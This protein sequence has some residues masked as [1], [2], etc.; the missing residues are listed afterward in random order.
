MNSLRE[1]VNPVFHTAEACLLVNAQ[2]GDK[3]A[4]NLLGLL[5]FGK[6]VQDT[7]ENDMTPEMREFVVHRLNPGF[8]TMVEA[9][10]T[11]TTRLILESGLSRVVDLPCGFTPRGLKMAGTAIDYYGLDLPAVTEKMAPVVES[12]IGESTKIAYRAVDATNL[13]SL[14][15]ALGASKEPVLIS[16]EGMLMYF[17]QSE[18]DEV[19]RNIRAILLE[20]GGEW[21]TVDNQMLSAQNRLMEVLLAGDPDEIEKFNTFSRE[22]LS[23][24]APPENAFLKDNAEQYVGNMGF[25]LRKVPVYD[26][27]PPTLHALDHLPGKEKDKARDVFKDMYFWIMTAEPDGEKILSREEEQFGISARQEG[28]ELLIALTGRLDTITSP[29]LL[30]EFRK[31]QEKNPVNQISIDMTH[32]SYISSAGLRVLLI[33]YKALDD[34]EC[35]KLTGVSKEVTEILKTT[36]FDQFFL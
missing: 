19:F 6:A 35:F 3:D 20:H 22:R 4:K 2:M 8:N 28:K 13:D 33:M 15:K 21:I 11:S 1:D 23:K 17:T 12:I 16:T 24:M 18:L 30:S 32:L 25:A 14:K 31:A 26:Y 10:F 7:K 5:D 27:L 9:R 36:G 34:K 29:E